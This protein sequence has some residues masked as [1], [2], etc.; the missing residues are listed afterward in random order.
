MNWEV[1]SPGHECPQYPVTIESYSRWGNQMTF[2]FIYL[3]LFHLKWG[4]EINK[5]KDVEKGDPGRLC[6]VKSHGG[7]GWNEGK[8]A[9]I[10][11]AFSCLKSN[12]VNFYHENTLFIL[13]LETFLSLKPPLSL[14]TS[15]WCVKRDLQR[16]IWKEIESSK[17]QWSLQT[18]RTQKWST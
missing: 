7:G 1:K 17:A 12:C 5:R 9:N 2:W 4:K 3:F 11:R 6:C 16:V 14:G 13:T 15:E 10:L 18:E 8:L